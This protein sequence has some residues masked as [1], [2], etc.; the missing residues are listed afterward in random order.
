M[1]MYTHLPICVSQCFRGRRFNVFRPSADSDTIRDIRQKLEQ[2]NLTACQVLNKRLHLAVQVDG[3]PKN[4]MTIVAL[5]LVDTAE[6]KWRSFN[7]TLN[8]ALHSSPY[9]YM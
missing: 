2:L 5:I 4:T 3:V 7:S 6:K 8:D 9:L 1:A